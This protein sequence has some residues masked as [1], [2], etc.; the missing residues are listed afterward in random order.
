MEMG[1][2]YNIFKDVTVSMKYA[3]KRT[4][5]FGILLRMTNYNTGYRN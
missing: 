2:T 3:P 4:H 1:P 5:C